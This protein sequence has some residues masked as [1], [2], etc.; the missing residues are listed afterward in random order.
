MIYRH[1]RA[2]EYETFDSYATHPLQSF[3][4]GEFRH[5][6]G[7]DVERLVGFEGEDLVSQLQLTFH[8]I[9]QIGNTIGYYPKGS[10]PDEVM[11]AALKEMGKRKK[12][13]FIKLEPNISTPPKNQAD[14]QGLR[15][16]LVE[17]GCV[18]GRPMFTPY[19]FIL[20]LRK[21]EDD[22]LA[23]MKSKTRYNIKIAQKHDVKIVEDTSEQGFSDYLNLLKLTTNRQ[24]FY[25]HTEAYHKSM[26][27]ALSQTKMVHILKAVYQDQVLTTWILFEFNGVLYYPYGASSRDHRDTMSSNLVMWEA[28]KLG[29]KLGCK[30][31]DMWGSLGP[32]PDTKDP[33]YGFHKFKEGY[34][35]DLAEFVGSYDLVIDP[36]KYKVFRLIDR[37]R[38]RYL[39]LKTKL[40]Q[41]SK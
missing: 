22:L 31:F 36:I 26:W 5:Q 16:F 41:L 30:S 37:W 10:W 18:L 33:W 29:K 38:W 1:P 23:Q 19:S 25:A 39:K 9:P 11:L 7:V 17:N 20:D 24:G 28:I 21:S 32:N 12:A 34:G 6:T 3:A 8:P 4:W 13:I 14:I 40:P 15:E 27:N 35:A 2:D